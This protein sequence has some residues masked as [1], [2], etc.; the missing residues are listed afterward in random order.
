[1]NATKKT[2]IKDLPDLPFQ[3]I[4]SYLSTAI[5]ST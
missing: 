2:T 3:Q 5:A 4:V 1:M